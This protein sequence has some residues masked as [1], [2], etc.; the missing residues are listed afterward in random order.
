MS[1]LE[2]HP[3]ADFFPLLDGQDF[4][5]SRHRFTILNFR[6]CTKALDQL[7]PP[8]LD[9]RLASG[10]RP[11]IAVAYARLF[12]RPKCDGGHRRQSACVAT[13]AAAL[14]P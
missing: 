11:A 8:T 2:F 5:E 6:F 1:P 9:A 7:L 13:S 14:W 10:S 3:L 12:F 4:A